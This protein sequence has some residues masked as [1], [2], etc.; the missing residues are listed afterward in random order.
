MSFLTLNIIFVAF[1]VAAIGKFFTSTCFK[2]KESKLRKKLLPVVLLFVG[3]M[4]MF[5]VYA[6]NGSKSWGNA[7][8]DGIVAS[9]ISQFVYDKV[10]DN[11]SKAKG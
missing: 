3:V 6:L 1:F 4:L 7:I 10:H 9:A 8:V 5:I 2:N 11:L